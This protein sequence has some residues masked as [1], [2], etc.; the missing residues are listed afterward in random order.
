MTSPVTVER[1]VV[2]LLGELSKEPELALLVE[3]LL[4]RQGI[5]PTL[6]SG[7]DFSPE[8][9]LSEGDQDPSVRVFVVMQSPTVARLYFRGPGGQRFI[10]RPLELPNGVDDVGRELL[11]QVIESSTTALLRSSAGITREQAVAELSPSKEPGPK[12][13]E[14]PPPV[15]PETPR[16]AADSHYEGW[17][18]LGLF[19]QHHGT[20]FSVALGPQAELGWGRRSHVLWRTRLFVSETLKQRAHTERVE[21][22]LRTTA[23][24]AGIDFGQVL[25][26]T[27][28]WAAG[29]SA[30]VDVTRLHPGEAR[31]PGL[32]P[33]R[34]STEVAP[35]IRPEFRLEF[36]KRPTYVVVSVFVD[37]ALFDTHYDIE[38]ESGVVRVAEPWQVRPGLAVDLGAALSLG[39]S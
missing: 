31:D 38:T 2:S 24:R 36:G 18:A 16:G 17:V 28:L 6:R 9:L 5:E 22:S 19:G 7:R 12:R 4:W 26:D 34:A 39:G 10:L 25:S 14:K 11:G 13:V 15:P 1:A 33:D 21:A 27:A 32:V 3:E 30:G 8:Q 23:L 35:L 29:L 37:W 20:D